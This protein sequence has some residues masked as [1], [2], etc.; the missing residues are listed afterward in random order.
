MGMR[1]GEVLLNLMGLALDFGPILR[2]LGWGPPSVGIQC[3]DI[4]SMQR[5]DALNA[6]DI[7]MLNTIVSSPSGL[8]YAPVPVC[9]R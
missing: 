2:S 3:F 5:F 4:Q 6:D 1:R 9:S 8:I 7:H